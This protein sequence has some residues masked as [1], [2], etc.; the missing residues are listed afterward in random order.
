MINVK[1]EVGALNVPSKQEFKAES[2][3]LGLCNYM[4]ERGWDLNLGVEPTGRAQG[5][6]RVRQR[7][8]NSSGKRIF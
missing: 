3:L 4:A 2:D 5:L 6:N 1:L 7:I 8:T